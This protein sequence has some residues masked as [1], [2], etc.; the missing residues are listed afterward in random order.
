MYE[1]NGTVKSLIIIDEETGDG[2]AV[3]SEGYDYARYTAFLPKIFYFIQH[4]LRMVVKEILEL[5]EQERPINPFEITKNM[6]FVLGS[7][8]DIIRL[9]NDEF[10]KLEANIYIE[11]DDIDFKI[12]DKN[13]EVKME[14]FF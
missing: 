14:M 10:E 2:L 9:L 6:S 1:F 12:I 13:Q 7:S 5:H 3:N 11:Y 8:G 4:E